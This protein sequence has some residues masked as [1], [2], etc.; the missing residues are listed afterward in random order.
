M[1]TL[2]C[3]FKLIKGVPRDRLGVEIDMG[4]SYL[5][6]EDDC[7]WL[8][9]HIYETPTC[10]V[11]ALTFTLNEVFEALIEEEQDEEKPSPDIIENN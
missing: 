9:N 1:I 5:Q 2:I 10:A 8:I 3:P 11:K 6:C 4:E 7:A